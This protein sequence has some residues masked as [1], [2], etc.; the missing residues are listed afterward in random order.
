MTWQGVVVAIVV[1]AALGYAVWR[2]GGFRRKHQARKRP[3]VPLSRLKR[4][5][6]PKD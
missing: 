5:P 2:L 3:D 4:R 6:P 1:A